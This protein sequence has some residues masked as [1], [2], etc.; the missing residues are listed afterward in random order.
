[1][2]SLGISVAFCQTEIDNVHTIFGI[3]GTSNQEIIWL[4]ISVDDA[5]LVALFYAFDHLS[6]DE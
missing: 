5:L 3:L 4:D 6:S 1:M 2:L